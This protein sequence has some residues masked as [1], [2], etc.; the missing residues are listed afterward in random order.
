VL[1]VTVEDNGSGVTTAREGS[2]IRGMRDRAQAVG[3]TLVAQPG[4]RRGWVVRAE[5]PLPGHRA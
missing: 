4:D 1:V 2:G 3:G 5:L